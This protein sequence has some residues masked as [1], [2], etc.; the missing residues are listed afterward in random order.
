MSPRRSAAGRANDE[1]AELR[2]GLARRPTIGQRPV[3]G[4]QRQAAVVEARHHRSA[5]RSAASTCGATRSAS[6]CSARSAHG[7]PD[8]RDA[9]SPPR[10]ARADRLSEA[11]RQAHLRPAV[12]GVPVQHQS[13]G[14]PAGRICRSPTWRCRRRPSTTSMPGRRRAIAR[15]ASTNGSRRAAGPRFVINAQN[16]V[17]CKTCD[18]KDPN[19]NI[20]WV[21]PEG[22]GGPKYSE[23]VNVPTEFTRGSVTIP[24]H[25]RFS[26]SPRFGATRPVPSPCGRTAKR[27]FCAATRR[28][29]RSRR[30]WRAATRDC[31]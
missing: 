10:N 26:W 16:C 24:P 2:G 15:P 3:E 12:L 30:P 22:G 20:T 6:R 7:K 31:S 25:C 18:I 13:R 21:P 1:L 29:W 28:A 27:P 17:H 4:A 23:Y 8:C 9:R 5:S 14:R 11:G 19:Q